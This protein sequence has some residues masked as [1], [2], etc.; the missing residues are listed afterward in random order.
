MTNRTSIYISLST[1]LIAVVAIYFSFLTPSQTK[2]QKVTIFNSPDCGCCVSYIKELRRKG[3]QVQVE[4]RD[5]MNLVKN[6]Y[7]IPS[8][9]ESC[10]TMII[11]KYFVEGH[12]PFEAIEKMFDDNLEIDGIALPNMPAGSL[13][14][15]GV[16]KEP[17]E[18]F[19]LKNGQASLYF[20]I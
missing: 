10:H 13:G 4:H 9:M 19:K 3:Y 12:V 20:S 2:A 1:L 17:F 16:K 7:H 5:D 6:K 14:M 11:D 8:E 18:I 15:P